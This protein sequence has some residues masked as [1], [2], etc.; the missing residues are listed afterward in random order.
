MRNSCHPEGSQS[1]RLASPCQVSNCVEASTAVCCHVLKWTQPSRTRISPR[2]KEEVTT[3]WFVDFHAED[4]PE[5]GSLLHV[6]SLK[7]GLTRS[8]IFR[9][10][11]GMVKYM[12]LRHRFQVGHWNK[13]ASRCEYD[14]VH[15]MS[16]A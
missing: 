14:S 9:R 2:W 13:S 4:S 8:A 3:S 6:L 16:D 10:L 7:M 15:V 12:L 1:S 11:S 5:C